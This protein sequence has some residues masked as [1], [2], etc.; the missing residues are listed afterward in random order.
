MRNIKNML[1]DRQYIK[2]SVYLIITGLV[3][4][5]LYSALS[6]IGLIL[7]FG[8][9]AIIEIIKA[10]APLIYGLIIAYFFSPLVNI[11]DEKFLNH[12]NNNT[13][14]KNYALS[15]QIEKKRRTLSIALAF[16][17]VIIIFSLL[18]YTLYS[19][20]VGK[21]TVEK[22][23]TMSANIITYF[24]KYEELLNVINDK[25]ASSVLNEK[26][27][28]PLEMLLDW[29]SSGILF[30]KG[31][32][33]ASW[34]SGIGG[35]L[36]NVLLGFVI[37][38]YTLKDQEFF[39]RLWKKFLAVLL[40]DQGR[41]KFSEILGEIHIVISKFFR[42]QL[43]DGLIV[44]VLSSIGLFIIG[45]DFSIFIGMFAGLANVIP[46]FGPIL[47]TIPAVIM[48][49][50]E[51]SIPKALLS[52]ILLLG[53]QQVDGA[54]IAPRVVGDSVGL[55]PVF[56]LLAVVI[57]GRYFGIVGM[58]LAVPTAAI[59]KLFILKIYDNKINMN[60][61]EKRRANRE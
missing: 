15:K 46:Y 18:L 33:V 37:S 52:I 8:G 17:L 44:G 25:L 7:S 42:G 19:M 3:F 22:I 41:E 9:K 40:P 36:F 54:V 49:L 13:T 35:N 26:I 10:V 12:F 24:S 30:K 5:I 31:G 21:V 60:S 29:V 11:I 58:L 27:K 20:I 50:L 4:Y 34:L 39:L 57:G 14:Y 47:G 59:L 6:H 56:V 48:A 55:H 43:L 61:R 45:I 2:F 28:N 51:G 38:F 53:I 32:D 16:I 1:F 23:D